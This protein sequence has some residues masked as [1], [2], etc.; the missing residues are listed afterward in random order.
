MRALYVPE[1]EVLALFRM[2][3]FKQNPGAVLKPCGMKDLTKI[4]Q[5]KQNFAQ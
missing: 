2:G 4:A 1:C 3:I 5:N